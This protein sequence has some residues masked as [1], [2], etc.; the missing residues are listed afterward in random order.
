MWLN[1]IISFSLPAAVVPPTCP[2]DKPLV[3][4]LVDPCQFATCTD[5]T[6]V[7][8]FCGGCNARFFDEDG[9]E[10][11]DTCEYVWEIPRLSCSISCLQ[12]KSMAPFRLQVRSIMQGHES[13]GM[14]LMKCKHV[15]FAFQSL[16][17]PFHTKV[18]L[19]LS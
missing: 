8:D 14:R 13:L 12:W 19:L 15:I 7:S 9:N 17:G 11:T 16:V 3:N 6:C 2:P 1:I 5:A 10:V 4:C 18:N